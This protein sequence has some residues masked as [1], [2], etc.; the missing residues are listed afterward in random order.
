MDAMEKRKILSLT[1]IE[2]RQSSI[3]YIMGYH[4]RFSDGLRTGRPGFESRQVKDF[5][6]LNNV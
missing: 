3:A 6:L 2:P 4:I 1:G 5:S